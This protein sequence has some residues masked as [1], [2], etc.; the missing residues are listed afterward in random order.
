MIPHRTGDHD[1]TGV[2]QPFQACGDIDPIAVDVIVFSD[3]VAEVD[4]DA[5][6]D[7]LVRPKVRVLLAGALLNLDRAAHGL[8]DTGE[9]RQEAGAGF[10]DERRA[11]CRGRR[12]DQI[13][14]E[15]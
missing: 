2:C 15:S 4:P 5:E 13:A 3:D 14:I 8:D 12:L 6:G 7:V 1:P 10:L 11:M 9:L